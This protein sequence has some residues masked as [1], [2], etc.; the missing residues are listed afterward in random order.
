MPVSSTRIC[1]YG[2]R[3]NKKKTFP[4][5]IK[6]LRLE[7]LCLWTWYDCWKM[8]LSILVEECLTR[9]PLHVDDTVPMWNSLLVVCYTL[10][11]SGEYLTRASLQWGNSL[12]V[13][14]AD[15]WWIPYPCVL[16]QWEFL[17]R[18]W[19]TSHGGSPSFPVYIRVVRASCPLDHSYNKYCNL[20]GYWEQCCQRLIRIVS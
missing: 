9:A 12:P 4:A 8:I 18:V 19:Y 2:S 11:R 14:C 13:V 20:I 1:L 17:A 16:Y 3:L 15:T 7:N 6:Y 10:P 5:I